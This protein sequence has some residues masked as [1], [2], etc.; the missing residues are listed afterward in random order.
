MSMK[1]VDRTGTLPGPKAV[2]LSGFND[3]DTTAIKHLFGLEQKEISFVRL[4]KPMLERTLLE[5][6]STKPDLLPP[7]NEKEVPQVMI[8]SGVSMELVHQV[9]DNLRNSQIKRPIIATTTEHN[10]SFTLKELLS[11]LLE[12][13]KEFAK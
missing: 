7:L 10:L 2:V 12:E 9:L 3:S 5:V 4:T 8:L 13:M 11:H 1:K 6:L